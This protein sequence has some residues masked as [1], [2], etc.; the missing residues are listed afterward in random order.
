MDNF[1]DR[2][3]F[4]FSR[5]DAYYISVNTKGAFYL[6]I[7]TF[8][9]GLF[10][11]K[12]DWLQTNFTISELTGFFICLF[13]VSC[14]LAIITT[15]LAIN[16]FLKSGE[17]YGKAKSIFYYGSV[18]EFSCSDFSKAFENISDDGL[19]DDICTQLHILATGLQKKFRLL[20]I[21][22]SLILVEFL[23][24]IPIVIMLTKNLN[25]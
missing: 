7:N 17:T 15:L 12:I 21:S 13:L 18:S 23:L 6:T 16:P 19:K 9:V 10:L 22:G 1:Y 4:S 14:F 8:F 25:K 24:L 5:Y 11:A 3:K 20:S 2:A